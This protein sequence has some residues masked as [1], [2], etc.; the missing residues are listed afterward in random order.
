MNRRE[1]LKTTTAL[2]ISTVAVPS[3][4][5]RAEDLP[6]PTASHLPRW[7]G[8]NL[9]EKCVKRNGGNPPFQAN[10]FALI[11][12]WGFDFTRLPLSYQCWSD[13]DDWLKVS[14]D[15]EKEL[16]H[17]DEAIKYGTSHGVH[18]N[19]NL[20]RAPGYCVNPPKE[21]LDLWKDEKALDASA[22]QWGMLA[23]R[24]QGIPN[25]RLS[26]D[27][28]NEPANV[29]DE[30]YIRVVKRL[31][32]AI[33]AADPQRLIIADGI[34]W[35]RDPVQ[36]LASLGIA[37]STRGYDPMQIT[38]YK[39]NWVN[40][41]DKWSEP[42]WPLKRDG[43]ADLDKE[44][45]RKDRIQPWKSL[46]QKGVGIHVGEWGAFNRTPH[47]V[48]VAWMADVLDLWKEA[49]WGWSLWNLRGGFGVLDSGRS[50][51]QYEDFRGRKLDREMLKLLQAG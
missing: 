38:H 27:L 15:G 17:L 18:V 19:L 4:C 12:E 46:E 23:K 40:G 22:H 29:P 39:A 11:S 35:G 36:G 20:H 42:S 24:F 28:L 1:F 26:F 7:R 49:G 34:R 2:T 32:E 43:K 8:F 48:V 41:S 25:E 9:T 31:V 5:L 21:P 30:T 13:K 33:R 6:K 45:L 16:K 10:D 3:L 47:K 51:V 37:Q 44:F 50:D 14:A